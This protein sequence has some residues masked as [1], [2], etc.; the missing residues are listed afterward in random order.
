M[1]QWLEVTGLGST[2][3]LEMHICQAIDFKLR[4]DFCLV[5]EMNAGQP[6]FNS[7]H[8]RVD[9]AFLHL[10]VSGA[11]SDS[12]IPTVWT[13]ASDA[14]GGDHGGLWWVARLTPW[15]VRMAPGI[16]HCN[17]QEVFCLRVESVWNSCRFHWWHFSECPCSLGAHVYSVAREDY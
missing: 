3:S 1:S 4:V 5:S 7:P 14:I 9:V 2:L 6:P 8:K 16:K 10:A 11:W 12:W 15:A 17:C 13:L